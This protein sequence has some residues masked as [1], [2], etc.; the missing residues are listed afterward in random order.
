MVVC[1][2]ATWHLFRGE[3]VCQICVSGHSIWQEGPWKHIKLGRMDSRG[4][5]CVWPMG[6]GGKE[7]RRT[8]HR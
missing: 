7:S 5:N 8:S 4:E 1:A 2:G 3:S 6:W